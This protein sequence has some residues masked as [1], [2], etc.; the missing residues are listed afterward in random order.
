MSSLKPRA[1]GCTLYQINVT[2]FADLPLEL[3]WH[4]YPIS[5]ANASCKL[6]ITITSFGVVIEF[7]IGKLKKPDDALICH[8]L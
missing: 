7:N 1:R 8:V 2:V 5:H 6:Y 4:S 3:L